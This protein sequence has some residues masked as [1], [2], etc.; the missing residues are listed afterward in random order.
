M[1]RK[2]LIAACTLTFA[3]TVLF[4]SVLKST[5]LKYAF[6]G[7]TSPTPAG[8]LSALEES[9]KEID[10][11]LPYPGVILPDHTLWSFKV[12]R[13]K[14][15][16]YLTLNS[17]RKA[18]LALLFADKRLLSSKILFEREKAELAFS[19]FTKAEKYLEEASI[20]ERENRE[21]DLDTSEFLT[22]LANASLKHRQVAEE[23]LLIAPEDARPGIILTQDYSKNIYNTSRAALLEKNLPVPQNPFEED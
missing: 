4:S 13:D 23:I 18:E 7:S 22:R 21:N 14:A 11:V 6:S 1:F 19:T 20:L 17:N 10:Y 8:V 5:S 15:W 12:L 9:D 2:I 3:F 16:F